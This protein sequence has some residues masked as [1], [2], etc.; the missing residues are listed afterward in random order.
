MENATKLLMAQKS[1][2]YNPSL[3]EHYVERLLQLTRK[4][5]SPVD[6]PILE[7]LPCHTTQNVLHGDQ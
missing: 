7:H 3:S 2:Q 5:K 4:T 6:K 1:L